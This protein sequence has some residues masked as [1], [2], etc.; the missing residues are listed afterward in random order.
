MSKKAPLSS[1]VKRITTF[2]GL[3][4][5]LFAAGPELD[6]ARKFYNQTDFDQSLQ[7]LRAIPNKDAA[8]YE[9]MGRNYYGQSDF[10]R[11]TEALERAFSA[12]PANAELA[13]WLG[14]AYGR[15]AETSSPFT[16]PGHASRARQYFEKSVELNPRYLDAL[17]DLFEYYTEAP[18]FL[19]GGMDKAQATA[20]KIAALSPAEGLRA[21]AQLA[22]KRKEYA[23][24]ERQLRRAIEV[25]PQQVGRFI[26]LARFLAKQGRVQEADQSLAHAEKVAP[27]SP[28]LLYARADIYIKCGRNLGVAKDLLKRYLSCKLTPDDPPRSEAQKLLRQV[29]G[30]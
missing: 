27:D 4:S 28:R 7:I 29:Q 15:R 26:D 30:S 9:L 19:G 18:G 11:A 22:E 20:E 23:S 16:A 25:A 17:S 6:H 12:E 3:A 21:Q 14:R 13:L 1:T 2:L 8:V 10:K 5:V 24:A